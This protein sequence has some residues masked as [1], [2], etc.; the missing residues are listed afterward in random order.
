MAENIDQVSISRETRK[1]YLIYAL[2]VITS[3]ALPDV[4]DGLKPVQRRILYTMYH[5]LHLY[6]EERPR[7]CAKIIGD[8]TG[9]YHPH[10]NSA[11]YEALARLAQNWVLREPLV[12]GQGNFGSVD[13]DGPAAERYTEA[14]LTPLAAA[15]MSELRQRTADMRP[16]YDGSREEPVVVPAQFP[17]ILVNGTAGIAVGMAT[18]IPPHNLGEVLRGCVHLIEDPEA[19]TAQLLDKV[20][21][22]D[23]PLGGKLVTDRTTLRKI[24]EEGTGSIKVQAEWKVEESAKKKQIIVTSIPYGVNKGNLESAIGEII[25]SRKLPQLTGLTNESNAKD[26]L[27]IALDIKPDADPQLVMAYLYKHSALQE[28]FAYNMTCLVPTPDGKLQPQRLGLKAILRHFLD[29]RFLTVKRRFEYE[30]EQLRRRIHI[31]E[32]FAIIFDALDKAIRLI[33]ESSGK[34]DAAEKLMKAF[35]LDEEQTNAILEAQLYKIAQMEIKKILDELKEKQAEAARIEAILKSD[36]KLWGVVK[37]ELEALAEKHADRRRT[38]LASGEDMPEFD[39]QAYIVRENTNVVL[40]RDG[41]IKRVGRLASV[42]GTRTREGDA[43]IAV[44]PGSTLDHV[45]FFA[46]DGT[47][48]TM[49]MNEVPASSGYGEPIGKFFRI[50]DQV[51]ILA[52]ISTDERFVPATIGKPKKDDPPGPYLLAVTANGL[53]LRTPFAPFRIESTKAGRRYIKLNDGDKVAMVTVPQNEETIYLASAN[54]HVLQFA[55]DEINILSGVGKGVIGIK[56]A[57]DDICLGGALMGGRFDKFTL[58]TS[59]GKLMEFGRNKYEPTSRG[60]KGFEAV[61]RANFARVVP[62]PIELVNWDEIEGKVNG[63]PKEPQKNGEQP[64]LFEE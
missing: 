21:G 59:G 10:G 58:E 25:V 9:N 31:L 32:G 27:R 52:A 43:V 33:R 49:R 35:K 5:D 42:E 23:F 30:L 64:T 11:A 36:K 51:K 22:P 34:A 41:W 46:D 13:G 54:G 6:A 57:D 63:K 38:R 1:S 53:T 4:R 16:N 39:E 15:L 14:R 19:T 7:K 48:Y 37:N 29:F 40:T 12:D 60:G 24:Y 18:N 3:R 55:I 45:V 47:A 44:V 50:D 8:V 17:N 61:K 28:N 62:P 20:R 26:G 2:S 56:L